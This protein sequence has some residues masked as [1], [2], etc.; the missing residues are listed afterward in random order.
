MSTDKKQASPH[1]RTRRAKTPLVDHPAWADRLSEEWDWE[2][3]DE[4]G[5]K[6]D[7]VMSGDNGK[8]VWWKCQ[9]GHEW[10]AKIGNR[11]NGTGCPYCSG[12][13]P[14]PGETDLGTTAPEVAKE[15]HPTRNGSLTPQDFK[16]GSAK[17]IWWLGSCGHEWQATIESRSRGRG[18]PLCER[19][20]KG[21]A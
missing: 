17:R 21:D 13:R 10:Q 11:V 9:R 8:L 7:K 5:I 18:C 12:N 4:L 16:R 6:P 15:W 19:R 3:N 14:I 1:K 2:K 20:K